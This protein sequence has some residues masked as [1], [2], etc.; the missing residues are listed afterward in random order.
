MVY[1]KDEGGTFDAPLDTV[2]KYIF[3][4]GEHDKVHTT[5]RKGKFKSVS[6]CTFLY[7]AERNHKG[8]WIP[9]VMRISFFPPVAMVQEWVKGPYAG[10]K[11]VYLY[12]PQG[13]K[14]GIDVYGE[15][16]SK[17]LSDAKLRTV[18]AKFLASEFKDDAPAVRK[19]AR[20]K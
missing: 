7:I 9:E 19:M 20:G 2:W 8:K 13:K 1:I 10:S 14:T 3:G 11:W 5:T 6:D 16:K 12:S 17:T 15:F 4:G 18:V